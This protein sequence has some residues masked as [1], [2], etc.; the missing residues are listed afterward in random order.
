MSILIAG[1][2]G[3]IGQAL[4]ASFD[5]ADD[6]TIV[7]IIDPR[8]D[9]G[10][11]FLRCD[12]TDRKSVDALPDA[13]VVYHMCAYNNTSHFYS[14]PFSVADNTL[15]P[16]VNLLHRYRNA[17]RFVYSSSSEV[18]AG[19]VNL[20][21]CDIPTPEVGT[22]VVDEISNPRWSYAGAKIMGEILIHGMHKEHGLP[23]VILRYHNVYGPGQRSHFIPEYAEHLLAGGDRLI[24][25]DQT[26]SF[27]FIDDA[28][29]ITRV[30][31]SVALNTTI[32]VGNPEETTIS[33]AAAHIRA[34]LGIDRVPEHMPALRGSV[35]RRL[36]D[37]SLLRS[38]IGDFT[39]TDLADGLRMTLASYL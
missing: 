3:F 39:F 15:T 18:Y 17:S 26:R 16:T 30:L 6:V 35:Q 23:Y 20:G 13:D 33:D 19:A 5:P 9:H 34:V 8:D 11:R 7:D 1:A 2:S 22:A 10:H 28:V 27:L 29:R 25:A 14:K 38:Y 4:A 12:L 32:N 24:G 21:I 36:A 31:A 37:T